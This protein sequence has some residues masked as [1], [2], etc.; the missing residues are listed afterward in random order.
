MSLFLLQWDR[1]KNDN[2]EK[3]EFRFGDATQHGEYKLCLRS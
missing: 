1:V 2:R 3:R